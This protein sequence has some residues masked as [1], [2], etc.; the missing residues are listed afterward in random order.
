[1]CDPR[2]ALSEVLNNPAESGTRLNALILAWRLEL[3]EAVSISASAT[4]MLAVASAR[5]QGNWSERQLKLLEELHRIS[6]SN[7][8]RPRAEWQSL[9]KRGGLI[10]KS[11]QRKTRMERVFPETDS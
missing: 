8:V 1:M 10:S 6:S 11:K 7:G 3:P 4:A 2:G 9:L 5:P